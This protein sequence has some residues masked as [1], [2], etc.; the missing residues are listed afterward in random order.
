METREFAAEMKAAAGRTE[1]EDRFGEKAFLIAV[2]GQLDVRGGMSWPEFKR[3]AV[4]AQK[5]GL[6]KLSR[7]DLV[8][9]MPPELVMPSRIAD[10]NSE[11]HLV[12]V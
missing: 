8:D 5:A 2:W 6:V 12:R 4:A 1:Q 7:A 3:M 9:A 10:G 11:W